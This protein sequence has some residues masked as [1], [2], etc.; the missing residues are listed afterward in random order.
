MSPVKRSIKFQIMARIVAV[1][2]VILI[3]FSWVL[4]HLFNSINMNNLFKRGSEEAQRNLIQAQSAIE[5]VYRFSEY[6]VLSEE[7]NKFLKGLNHYTASEK[8]VESAKLMGKLDAVLPGG[9][10]IHSFCIVTEDGESF[11]SKCPY[12]QFF[13][14]WFA[15]NTGRELPSQEL[16]FTQ[17]YLFPEIKTYYERNTLVSCISN[18]YQVQNGRATSRGQ[19]VVQLNLEQLMEEIFSA[20]SLFNEIVVLDENNNVLYA[21][22][23]EAGGETALLATELKGGVEQKGHNYYVTNIMKDCNWKVISKI[24]QNE[25]A[26]S[27]DTPYIVLVSAVIFIALLLLF[28]FMFPLLIKISQQIT[29]LDGAIK[30]MSSGNLDTTV[31]LHGVQELENISQGFN[32]MVSNTKRYMNQS[33]ESL[34]EQQKLQFEL[35]LAKINPHFIYNTLNSVIYLARQKKSE[36]IISLTGAFIHLLQDS[37]HLGKNRLFEEVGEEVEVVKQYIIIQNYRYTGRFSFTCECDPALLNTYIPKNILQPIIENSILH[38]ICPRMEP[39]NIS[40]TLHRRGENVEIVI[41]DDGVGMDQ[42]KIDGLFSFQKNKAVEAPKMRHIGLNNVAQRL[43]FI[44]P[45]KHQF[46]VESQPG[47]GTKTIIVHPVVTTPD[48]PNNRGVERD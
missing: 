15:Q 5:D 44:F 29:R 7:V 28:V 12:D 34:K 40:L 33:I 42:E 20:N 27:L 25:F 46:S 4:Y 37:I 2:L 13:E 36:D 18:I 30:E 16:G 11:W 48:Y 9:E 26:E 1:V 6:L 32:T 17:A 3:S 24:D 19:V 22:G 38:G 21:S 39:G 43:E 35:L 23:E 8:A 31:K 41:T 14:D 47:A 10:Y 45:G